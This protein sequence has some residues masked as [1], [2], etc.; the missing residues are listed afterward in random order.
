MK[1]NTGRRFEVIKKGIDIRELR[2]AEELAQV[3]GGR[4]PPQLGC[5]GPGQCLA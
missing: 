5:G 4:P 1:K 2:S 3:E